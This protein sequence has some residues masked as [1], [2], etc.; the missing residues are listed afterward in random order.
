MDR[1]TPPD[2]RLVLDEPVLHRAIGSAK[3]MA[4]QLEHLADMS[5]RP[6]VTVQVVPAGLGAHGGLLGAFI[7]AGSAGTVHLGTAVEAQVTGDAPVRDRAALIFDRLTRDALPRGASR[8]LIV[9]VA[10]E[11]WNM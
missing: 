4:A 7:I 3:I 9:K 5:C 1:E 11:Q 6:M 8:D 10:H 2:L